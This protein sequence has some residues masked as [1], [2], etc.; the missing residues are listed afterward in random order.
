[1]MRPTW[2]VVALATALLL[3]C[4]SPGGTAAREVATSSAAPNAT[5]EAKAP[6]ADGM[7]K[8]HGVLEAVCTKC[9]PALAAVF[10]A[11][12]DWC[13]EHGFPES[14]C[15]LCHP[16][17]GGRPLGDVADDGAP[18]AGTKIQ[19]AR[20]G[21]GKLAGIETVKAVIRPGGGSVLAPA[22]ITYDATKVAQVNARSPG[23]VLS[24][25][26]DVGAKVAKG[27]PL[28]VIDSPDVG[29]DR[30]RLGSARARVAVAEENYAREL[31]LEKDGI[32]ARRSVLEAKGDL[33][34]AKGEHAALSAALSV[35]GAGGGGIGGY[36]LRAPI[37]GVVTER[38]ASIGKLVAAEQILYEIVDTS[39][40]WADL[41]VPEVDAARVTVGGKVTITLDALPG[42]T[43]SGTIAYVAPSIDE[44]TRTAKARVALANDGGLLR[45]N[46]FGQAR[47]A[48]EADRPA[49]MVPRS[50]IQRAKNVHL[51]FV[52]T[53]DE[54]FET[55]RVE[56]GIS[57][58]E[59]VEVTKGLAPGDEVVT[60][61]S[62]L[63]KTE[64]SKESIGAGCCAVD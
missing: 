48:I 23:V 28:A 9:N 58:G 21:T 27:A 63:L 4:N 15:P 60:T 51:A 35:M 12:G 53:G 22:R 24:L 40:L 52:R 56:L 14:F 45:A 29:A 43:L 44:H 64:T 17:R 46:M 16:E 47:I 30:A 25:K 5:P 50:A 33:D 20:A 10:K 6:S 26:V 13:N 54:Q 42:R 36:T 8:E 61:G 18:R 39:S 57:E 49:V 55:R 32:T 41:D 37:A 38:N 62:F 3:G 7:C 2:Y 11:K 59:L 1:M 31:Q 34:A 19:L